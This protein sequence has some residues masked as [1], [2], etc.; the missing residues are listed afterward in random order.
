MTEFH[1]RKKIVDKILH[2]RNKKPYREQASAFANTNIAL[3]KY[4]GKRN[5]SLILPFTSS[6]SYTLKGY[7]THTSISCIS[8]VDKAIIDGLIKQEPFTK[9]NKKINFET[10]TFSKEINRE[11]GIYDTKL[12]DFRN[13]F[14]FEEYSNMDFVILNGKLLSPNCDFS[15]RILDFLSLFRDKNIFFKIETHNNFPTS[16]GLAS[17]ASGAAALV[18]A[19]DKIYHWNLSKKELSIL[20][21]LISGSGCRSVYDCYKPFVL[22][23]KGTSNTGMDSFATQLDYKWPNLCFKVITTKDSKTKKISS[24]EAMKY[25]SSSPYYKN[26]ESIVKSDIKTILEAIKTKD[27]NVFGQT[28]ERNALYMHKIIETT[29][30]PIVYFS[31]E[32]L[33]I[34]EAIKKLRNHV[35]IYFTID[36]GP[37]V[38]V[39]FLKEHKD[40]VDNSIS[41]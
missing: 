6:L 21:R 34:I 17:S 29:K 28:I 24:R 11:N 36:A 13:S 25:A 3:V 16:A 39:F 10:A 2:N 33:T 4:W 19:L 15:R 41:V 37:N 23:D 26:W 30:N 1:I 35:P 40:V 27:F 20:A 12:P 38:V 5:E 8:R 31:K 7:S 18:M 14:I 22:W 9:K 32:T